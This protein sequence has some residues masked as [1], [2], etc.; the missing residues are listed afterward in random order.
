MSYNRNKLY[1]IDEDTMTTAKKTAAPKKTT[2]T[3]AYRLPP[4]LAEQIENAATVSGQT[5]TDF[6]KAALAAHIAP[7]KGKIEKLRQLRAK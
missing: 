6:V 4:E 7:L 5:Q 2:K 1:T 3:V